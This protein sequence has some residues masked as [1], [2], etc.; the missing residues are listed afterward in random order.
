[1]LKVIGVDPGL[2]A[3]GVGIVWGHDCCVSGYSFGTIATSSKLSTTLRL[4]KIYTKL[5]QLL[6]DEAPDIMVIEDIFTL[7]KYPKSGI[8]LGKVSGVIMLSGAKYGLSV[9]EVSVREAKQILSGNGN[10]TKKQLER[11]VRHAI[12]HPVEIKPDHASDALALALIGL[13]RS[14]H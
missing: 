10:A 14:K 3:T 6:E 13:F 12:N 2:A 4:K 5:R 8:M 7:D 1:M 9:L 11:S